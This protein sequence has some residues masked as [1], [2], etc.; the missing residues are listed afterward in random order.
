MLEQHRI[1]AASGIE[2]TGAKVDIHQ[3]HGHHTGQYRHNRYQQKSRNQPGPDEQRQLHH[4]H[5]RGAHVK[6]GGDDVNRAHDRAEAHHVNRKDKEGY[7]RRRI[8]G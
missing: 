8:G 2:E 3:H 6:D 1:T 5:A 7:A 4:R